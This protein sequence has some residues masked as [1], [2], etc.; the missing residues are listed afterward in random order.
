MEEQIKMARLNAEKIKVMEDQ[1]AARLA[2]EAA[3]AEKGGEQ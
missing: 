3:E 1:H 2:R